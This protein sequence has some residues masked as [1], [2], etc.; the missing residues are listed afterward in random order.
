MWGVKA[1]VKRKI[2]ETA[3]AYV[4]HLRAGR[5]AAAWL[6]EV[7]SNAGDARWSWVDAE[8]IADV[9]AAG[10]RAPGVHAGKTYRLGYDA[11]S[12]TEIAAMI[13]E[14]IG[15]P[16]RYE[17]RPPEEFLETLMKASG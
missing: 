13:A 14:V 7:E 9:A 5:L 12:F 4:G 11:K 15:Q 1:R 3:R 2:R 6:T 8:D 16:F 17:A 10:L